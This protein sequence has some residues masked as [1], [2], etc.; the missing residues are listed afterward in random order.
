MFQE[1]DKCKKGADFMR[2]TDD[3]CCHTRLPMS[4]K[5]S[6]FCQELLKNATCLSKLSTHKMHMQESGS[7]T[8]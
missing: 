5:N 8:F 3:S 2:K 1:N 7:L 6:C 4:A